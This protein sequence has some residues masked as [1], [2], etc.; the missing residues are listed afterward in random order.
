MISLTI[1]FPS[2]QMALF[3]YRDQIPVDEFFNEFLYQNRPCLI[4]N[5]TSDWN[6]NEWSIGERVNFEFLSSHFG[7]LSVP[8]ADCDVKEFNA[9]PKSDWLFE[10]YLRYW[11]NQQE[12][13]ESGGSEPPEKEE[14]TSDSKSDFRRAK[15]SLYLKDWHFIRD[16]TGYVPY[17]TPP[18]FRSDWLNEFYAQRTDVR[19]DYKFV[20]MGPKGTWTPLHYDV[21]RSYSWSANVVG[22]KLWIIFPKG[23]EKWLKNTRGELEYDAIARLEGTSA[24]EY[25]A[26][27]LRGGPNTAKHFQEFSLSKEELSCHE[28]E[29]ANP[30]PLRVVV[31]L[32]RKGETIFIPSGWHHQV[33]NI[34]DVISIN[35]NWVNAC[36]LYEMWNNLSEELD[37]VRI[38]ISDCVEMEGW[39]A[40]C[41]LILSSLAGM[42]FSM[43]CKFLLVIALPRLNELS[44]GLSAL[45]GFQSIGEKCRTMREYVNEYLI[46][47]REFKLRP[48]MG[49]VDSCI[50]LSELL[51]SFV[52]NSLSAA[53]PLP[54][55]VIFIFFEFSKI[56]LVLA[57]MVKS[58]D[59]L[60]QFQD[61][62]L[63][64]LIEMFQKDLSSLWSD[65]TV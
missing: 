48:E 5:M 64:C 55:N 56:S 11:K 27:I 32:Q 59:I 42:D 14:K 2:L 58:K 52:P 35:H 61:S 62:N 26:S 60:F 3:S 57:E 31:V 43:L 65:I 36:N 45:P 21:F 12:V 30:N 10:S 13:L 63:F 9:N 40:Q 18:I 20:Y 17:S 39:H 7:H 29:I 16:V 23:D 54:R 19:D 38:S 51:L 22:T 34:D 1:P 37:R 33:H 53:Q 6:A 25:I 47:Q 46:H 49:N 44:H 28:G 8:V 15:S 50:P 24:A 41:Q 4:S